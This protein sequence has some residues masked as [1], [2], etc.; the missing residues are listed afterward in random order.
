MITNLINYTAYSHLN[1]CF[2]DCCVVCIFIIF[3]FGLFKKYLYNISSI[4]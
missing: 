2:T 4:Q 3:N 1:N